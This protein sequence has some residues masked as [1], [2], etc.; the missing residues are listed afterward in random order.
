MAKLLSG[1]K[2]NWTD[3]PL[4]AKDTWDINTLWYVLFF[5]LLVCP[6][7]LPVGEVNIMT[8]GWMNSAF[9]RKTTG[10]VAEMLPWTD[11]ATFVL[12]SWFYCY[13]SLLR[14]AN[15]TNAC[16]LLLW[17]AP[18]GEQSL[19]RFLACCDPV[20]VEHL[21]NCAHSLK[22]VFWYENDL[23]YLRTFKMI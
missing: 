4:S 23:I 7:P 11:L 10:P 21:F 9:S 20:L 15:L 6:L 13:H 16:K 5:S 2:G 18:V 3:R 22:Q 19:S 12:C 8:R 17:L 14:N 1:G